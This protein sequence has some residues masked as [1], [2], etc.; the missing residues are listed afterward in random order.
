MVLVLIVLREG[1]YS[2]RLDHKG[3]KKTHA[4]FWTFEDAQDRCIMDIHMRT[5]HAWK[6]RR[7]AVRSGRGRR[8]S[9]LDAN[10]C[11]QHILGRRKINFKCFISCS[12]SLVSKVGK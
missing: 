11:H 4:K 12:L 6:P 8:S 10:G 3:K 1:G 2:Y 7:K 5:S 9:L